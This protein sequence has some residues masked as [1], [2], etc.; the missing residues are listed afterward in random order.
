[1]GSTVNATITASHGSV[2]VPVTLTINAP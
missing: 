1:V 2:S